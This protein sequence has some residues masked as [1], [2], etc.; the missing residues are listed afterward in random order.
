[1]MKQTSELHDLPFNENDH[2]NDS[3]LLDEDDWSYF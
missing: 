2:D 3:S 1:L